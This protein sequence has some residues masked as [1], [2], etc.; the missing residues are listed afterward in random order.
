MKRDMDLIRALLLKLESLPLESGGA[1]LIHPNDPIVAIDGYSADQIEYHLSL[2]G[3]R[4]L[5]ERSRPMVGIIFRRI[6]WEGH[7]FLDA[8]RDPEIWRKTKKGAEEVGSFTFD[9]LKELAVGLI[10][11]KIEQHTGVEL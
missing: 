9:L 5:I 6:T 11:T 4:E 7:D 10:K 1:V 2:L 3:E 8:I